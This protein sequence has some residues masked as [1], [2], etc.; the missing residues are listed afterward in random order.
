MNVLLVVAIGLGSGCV[1]LSAA[2]LVL[3]ALPHDCFVAPIQARARRLS[4][5]RVLLFGLRNFLG[6]ILLIG[7][8]ILVLPVFPLP[9]G[10]G[11]LTAL[12]GLILTDLPGKRLL[13]LRL[14]RPKKVW[15][16]LNWI[17]RRMGR[18]EFLL[19][20]SV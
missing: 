11:I 7:G 4:P 19:P 1:L 17:R 16:L 13:L 10:S 2:V 14:I 9:P 6:M 5:R 12:V 15:R 20:E 8:L 3:G 18:E